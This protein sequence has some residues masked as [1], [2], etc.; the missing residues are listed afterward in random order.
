MIE[1]HE[2]YEEHDIELGADF[3]D[4]HMIRHHRSS[5]RFEQSLGTGQQIETMYYLKLSLIYTHQNCSH[6]STRL[7]PQLK[8]VPNSDYANDGRGDMKEYGSI[9]KKNETPIL[10][11]TPKRPSPL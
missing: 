9:S 11:G 1:D 5:E 8:R 2:E 6:I 10:D 4:P 3:Y 7:V